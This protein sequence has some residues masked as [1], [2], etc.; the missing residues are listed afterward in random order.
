ME[1]VFSHTSNDYFFTD[2]NLN[3]TPR[4][5]IEGGIP[6]Y[7]D[8]LALPVDTRAPHLTDSRLKP[9]FAQVFVHRSIGTNNSAQ[10]V[11]QIRGSIPVETLSPATPTTGRATMA[12]S[13][14]A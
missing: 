3:K 13:P 8:A 12:R 6:V 5:T 2:E 7:V 9:Q 4:F 1:G 14:A 10:G 11:V